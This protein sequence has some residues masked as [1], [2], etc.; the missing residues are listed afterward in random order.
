LGLLSCEH[1]CLV[2]QTSMIVTGDTEQN[3]EVTTVCWRMR[4]SPESSGFFLGFSMGVERGWWIQCGFRAFLLKVVKKNLSERHAYT[5]LL[6]YLLTPWSRVLLEKLTGFQLV[7]KV[8]AFY[9]TRKF[10]TAFTRAHHLSLSWASPIQ[11][12][13]PHPTS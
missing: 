7:K 13:P 3:K 2:T 5:Y 9:G 11:S 12:V 8:P 10:I 1:Y 4:T 6:T